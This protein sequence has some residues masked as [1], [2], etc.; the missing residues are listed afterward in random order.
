MLQM[1]NGE[2][3]LQE[4]ANVEKKSKAPVIRLAPGFTIDDSILENITDWPGFKW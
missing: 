4:K 1:P 2:I 3:T